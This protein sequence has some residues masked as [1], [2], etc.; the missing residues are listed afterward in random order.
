MDEKNKPKKP[1][2]EKA[3]YDIVTIRGENMDCEKC[4]LQNKDTRICENCSYY[5]ELIQDE[6]D[7]IIESWCL[8][9]N[10]SSPPWESCDD[11]ESNQ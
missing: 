10:W 9:H 6:F 1:E 2:I 3:I 5:G 11:F 7:P 4:I 8:K